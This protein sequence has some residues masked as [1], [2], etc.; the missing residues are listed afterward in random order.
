MKA[1]QSNMNKQSKL[2]RSKISL[3]H[4]DL[5]PHQVHTPKSGKSACRKRD[6]KD[7]KVQLRKGNWE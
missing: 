5:K 1:D 6:R 3:G 4:L 7:T 2:D